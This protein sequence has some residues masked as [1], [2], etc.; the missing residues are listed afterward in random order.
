MFDFVGDL[1]DGIKGV[2]GAV[3]NAIRS[4]ASKLWD[5]AAAA[6]HALWDSV[7]KG[8]DFANAVWANVLGLAQQLYATADNIVNGI[9]RQLRD[10][11]AATFAEARR[12]LDGLAGFVN[13]AVDGLNAGIR[14]VFD[15]VTSWV[16]DHVWRPLTGALDELRNAIGA[17]VDFVRRYGSALANF[18]DRWLGKLVR[19]LEDPIGETER[20][21]N[22]FAMR[23]PKAIIGWIVNAVATEGGKVAD[24][25]ERTLRF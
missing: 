10:W 23:A 6:V 21:V 15:G 3:A 4:V 25:L 17:V 1:Y 24:L 16:L 2:P 19:W 7:H 12:A 8:W 5:R 14:N 9:I 20:W 18:V 22:D 13:R 11:A